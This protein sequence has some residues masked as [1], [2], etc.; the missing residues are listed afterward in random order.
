[1]IKI[2]LKNIFGEIAFTWESEKN[3]IKETVEKLLKDN[4]GNWI[5]GINLSGYNLSNIDFSNSKFYNSQFY[6]SQFDNSKFDNSKFD[7]SK[8][9]NSK[10]DNSKFYNSQFY[11]SQFYNIQFDNSQFDNSKFDNSKFYNFVYNGIK[12]KKISFFIGLYKYD[13]ASIISEDDKQYIRLGCFTR[14]VSE[15]DADFWNNEKEF[16]NDGSLNSQYR[17]IAFEF[18]KKW[19]ELNK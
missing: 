19:I 13:C 7:N 14:L 16:P 3:T 18:C 1:M 2:E 11:N 9:Y 8:F 10:F 4:L 5:K 12:V 17:V 15:W 6:N